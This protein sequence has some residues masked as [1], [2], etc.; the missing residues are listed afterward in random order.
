MNQ[1]P[2]AFPIL[3]LGGNGLELTDTGMTLRDYLAAKALQG[4]LAATCTDER[5]GAG[6]AAFA[7][8]AYSMADAML[9]ERNKPNTDETAELLQGFLDYF[10]GA[11][12]AHEG[13]RALEALEKDAL[14]YRA[15]R[16]GACYMPVTI[17]KRLAP[18]L[19]PSDI[20]SMLDEIR[21]AA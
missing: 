15:W 6:C 18:C 19:V 8:V 11:S 21:G 10:P 3:E 13:Y 9:A 5:N 12:D 7:Q 16:D 1:I 4:L 17:V 2:H 20:D 14:R